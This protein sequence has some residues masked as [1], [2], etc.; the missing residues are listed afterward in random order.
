MRLVISDCSEE[1]RRNVWTTRSISSGHGSRHRR[2]GTTT[3]PSSLNGRGLGPRSRP[4]RFRCLWNWLGRCVD[5]GCHDTERHNFILRGHASVAQLERWDGETER[6]GHRRQS[7]YCLVDT[8]HHW[9]AP[10]VACSSGKVKMQIALPANTTIATQIYQF[11][12]EITGTNSARFAG[13][14]QTVE[15]RQRGRLKAATKATAATDLLTTTVVP[16]SADSSGEPIPTIPP[17]GYQQLFA[18]DFTGSTLG[19]DWHA[20][21]GD[22][23]GVY[24]GAA[25]TTGSVARDG[26]GWRSH[27]AHVPGPCQRWTEQSVGRGWRRLVAERRW[28][29][30]SDLR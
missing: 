5:T 22:T 23:F 8:G 21:S 9:A 16:Q 14:E 29:E 17:A 12:F 4:C 26:R 6:R 3:P 27:V 28:N 11:S 18:D 19:P 1:T 30:R 15:V 24:K 7:V 10:L 2:G 13:S 20:Y 25:G